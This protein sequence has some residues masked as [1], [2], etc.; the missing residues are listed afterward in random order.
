MIGLDANVVVRYLTQDDARQAALAN[1]L[2]ENELSAESPGFISSVAL[3]E[4]VWVLEGAYECTREHVAAV[5]DQLLRTREFL[6]EEAEAVRRAVRMFTNGKADF[7]DCLI[8]RAGNSIGF[9]FT[10]TFDRL[11]ARDAG[12]RL[13]DHA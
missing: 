4:I 5:L 12:M 1:S 8:E 2:V 7:A 11:A 3:V 13:L 6:V 9:D 10:I